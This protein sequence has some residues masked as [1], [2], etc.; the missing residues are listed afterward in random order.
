MPR[1]CSSDM[2]GQYHRILLLFIDGVGLAASTGDNPFA[3][4]PSPAIRSLLGGPM[5]REQ[6]RSDGDLLLLALDAR[7]GVSGLPQSATGQASLFT[8]SNAARLMGRHVTGL[9]GPRLRELVSGTQGLL[10][11]ARSLGLRVTFANAYSRRYLGLLEAGRARPSVTTCLARGAE[12]RLRTEEDLQS[13][14]AVPWDIVGDVFARDMGAP[15]ERLDARAAGRRLATIAAG[16]DLTLFESFLPDLVGH[17]R[18]EMATDDV[19]CRLDDLVTGI[20]DVPD[21]RRTLVLTSDHGNFEDRSSHSHTFNPVPLLVVG[22]AARHLDRI[23]S[24]E[25]LTPAL[26]GVLRNASRAASR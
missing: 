2:S 25:H 1:F 24:I 6:V 10:R 18:L 17:H 20:L 12:V 16:H 9:P 15:R 8:G 26:L 21:D 23:E 5:T 3:H 13:G 4:A 7:L 14:R 11:Q 22:P 19:V